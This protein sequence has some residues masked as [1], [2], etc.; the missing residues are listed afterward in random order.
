MPVRIRS[1]TPSRN[2]GRSWSFCRDS[3]PHSRSY[4]VHQFLLYG[5]G[6]CQTRKGTPMNPREQRG[7]E[8]A[9]AANIRRTDRAWYVPSQNGKGHH[10]S[11]NLDGD[12]PRCTCPDYELRRQKCKH[13]FAVEYTLK[14]EV[15][16]NG[17]VTVTETKRVTYKQDWSAYNAAQTGEKAR[18]M[19]LLSDLCR[20]IQQPIQANGRPR[21]PLSDMVFA[22]VT[23]VYEGFSAR[24]FTCDL[25]EAQVKGLIHRAAHFNSVNRYLADPELTEILKALVT[26]SSLPLKAVE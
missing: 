5:F 26:L 1:A 10:Y 18:F 12:S 8:L 11:V 4:T 21:L 20:S 22:V 14:Q 23:K 15:S 16:P 24:R 2:P 13:I 7:L 6:A 9:K 25:Q 17:T 3:E 19:P